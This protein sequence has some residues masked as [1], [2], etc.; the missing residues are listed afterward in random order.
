MNKPFLLKPSAKDYLWGGDRLKKYYNKRAGVSPL[1][2]T[3]ECST[4]PDGES[5]AFGKP[6]S[7]VLKA[8]PE[9]IGSRY[10]N[11]EGRLP[12]L[13][14]FID[15]AKNL[16]VQVHP[17]DEYAKYEGDSGKTEMWYVLEAEKGAEIVYGFNRDVSK[18]ELRAAV[19][20]GTV[21]KYLC[22]VP[23]KKDDVFFI[24]AGT[25]HAIGAGCL[26]AEI[27]QS[28][29][30]TYRLYDYNRTDKNGKKRALH[31]EKALDVACLKGGGG[32]QRGMRVL[33]YGRGYASDNVCRCS[34]FQ[35]LRLLVNTETVGGATPEIQTDAYSFNVLL[36]TWGK[37]ALTYTDGSLG[38][39]K[40]DCVFIPANSEKITL[41][42]NFS[43]LKVS[44]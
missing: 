6:L 31:V 22:R 24:D 37:G 42:G 11:A 5:F 30:L 9:Y 34:Y 25:V 26:V 36:C 35:V 7:E 17:D 20:N 12:V 44:V 27:Q 1:A 33:R 32:V 38:F 41:S 2:E 29:N 43:V 21:E 19:E 40:G 3:W 13:I 4:H 18:D 23:V 14:K 16:S 10:A 28:S 8:H 39:C 15:A